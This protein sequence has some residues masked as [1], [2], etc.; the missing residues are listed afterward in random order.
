MPRWVPVTVLLHVLVLLAGCATLSP[1]MH[2]SPSLGNFLGMADIP[3]KDLNRM[4]VNEE[5]RFLEVDD[6]EIHYRDVGE[7]PVI[8]LVHGLFSSL[9]TWEGWVEELRP[10]FRVITL[11]L[12]GFGL[13][14]A[15]ADLEIFD[16]TYLV[17]MF[18][19][20]ADYLELEKFSI[21]GNSMGGYVAARYAAENPGRVEKLILLDPMGYPQEKPWVF[22]LGTK[23]GLKTLSRFVQPPFLVTMNLEQVYGDTGRLSKANH[24]R[25]IHLSQRP[26]AKAAYIKAMHFLAHDQVDEGAPP[27][28]MP[29]AS[30]RAPTLLLW[31]EEDQWVPI[32][33][34]ERWKADVGRLQFIS[35]PGVG[36]VP[37][38]EL[39]Y[40]TAQDAIAFL[41]DLN[42]E[43]RSTTPTVDELEMLI[44]GDE[45]SEGFE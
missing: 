3:L 4:Y 40:Q 42:P 10:R 11:D 18:G 41:S 28:S 36:H 2:A 43:N 33:L 19:K 15:P 38:E 13:T 29:F 39:P 44:Q 1:S 16:E 20:F 35:Y 37:M 22:T 34:A 9:H 25:Y 45:F 5:S 23:P 6:M 7:G 17:A 31:G 24:E 27:P 30:I 21:A 12:P 14:G 26:G 8:V 32:T